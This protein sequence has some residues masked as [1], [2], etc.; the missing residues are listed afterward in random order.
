MQATENI[1][2]TP[3]YIRA[4]LKLKNSNELN[5]EVKL[6]YDECGFL[7]HFQETNIIHRPT[8]T[9]SDFEMKLNLVGPP[10]P[11]EVS[12]MSPFE[13]LE[14]LCFVKKEHVN[15][16]TTKYSLTPAGEKLVTELRKAA[17]AVQAM[18]AS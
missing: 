15:N 11:E 10:A 4:I 12:P 18:A 6:T 14:F 9:S 1:E 8:K 7:E 16:E 5:F 13:R 3:N 2:L 17:G